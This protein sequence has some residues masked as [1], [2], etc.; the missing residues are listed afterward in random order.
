MRSVSTPLQVTS[1]N[2]PSVTLAAQVVRSHAI[3]AKLGGYTNY[4]LFLDIAQA[5]YKVIRQQAF[6]CSFADEDVLVFLK[7]MGVEDMCLEDVAAVL[8][9]GSTLTNSQCDPFLHSQVAEVHR[10]TW[11]VLNQDPSATL[12]H[13]ERG[14]RPGDG[15]ADII[16]SLVFSRWARRFEERLLHEELITPF[17]WNGEAGV[18]SSSGTFTIPNAVVIWADDVVVLGEDSQADRAPMK[19]Q[20]T[21]VVMVEELLRFGLMANFDKGKTEAVITPRGTGS[22]QVKRLI[23]NTMKSSLP[24]DTAMPGNPKLRLVHKYKH[25]GG[26]VT[27]GAKMRPEIQHRVAQA[28]QQFKTYRAKVYANP[29]ID[30]P[31]RMTVLTATALTTLHY[32]AGIWSSLTQ[33]EQQMWHTA[34]MKLYRGTLLKLFTHKQILHMTDDQVLIHTQQYRPS[35]TLRLLRLRWY[36]GAIRRDCE[37]LWAVLAMEGQ[38]LGLVLEDL[39]WTYSQLKGFTVLPDPEEDIHAW[40][41]L[42]A[43]RPGK[44]AGLLKRAAT[45]DWLQW[46]MRAKVVDYHRRALDLLQE[47]GAPVPQATLEYKDAAHHCF[48][49]IQDFPTYRAWAVHSFKKHGRINKWR[50]LQRGATCMACAR[51]FP[52]EARLTRHL[53][54]VQTCARTVASLELWVPKQPYFGSSKV[55]QSEEQLPMDV[56]EDTDAQQLPPEQGI[57][58]TAEMH[59]FL[60]QALQ[61]D[62]AS[63]PHTTEMLQVLQEHAV[64]HSE[65]LEVEALV[66]RQH[67]ECQD[68]IATTFN[69][70]ATRSR[71]DGMV[72]SRPL[73]LNEC[74]EGLSEVQH[75]TPSIPLRMP[76][77]Y[78]YILHLYAGVRREGDFH[79]YMEQCRPPDGYSFFVASVDLVLDSELGDLTSRPAQSY[80]IQMAARGGVYA[81]LGGPPCESWSVARFR[82]YMTGSGPRPVRSGESLMEEIWGLKTLRL[83][84]IRQ[85]DVANQLLLFMMLLLVV[86]WLVGGIALLEH[87]ELPQPKNDRQPPSI[88]LTPIFKFIGSLKGVHCLHI[89]QGYWGAKSPKP[90]ALMIIAR[91]VCTQFLYDA[92]DSTRTRTTLPQALPMGRVQNGQGYAT[93]ELKRYPPALC[94]G[95]CAICYRLLPYIDHVPAKD[96][97]YHEVFQRFATAYHAS[98]EDIDGADYVF[99]PQKHRMNDMNK[100]GASNP[101]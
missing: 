20:H 42:M 21:C 8:E 73:S 82:Y 55:R 72:T 44:W 71:P 5:F 19:L 94:A 18:L 33:Y 77:R 35:V 64:C 34:H 49:C 48:I 87:P 7:R 40:H 11:F 51:T 43:T 53:R 89:H 57:P 52:A 56:W 83:R 23:F 41:T 30:I 14:T 50:R 47:A 9:G 45:H 63:G 28:Q 12:V 90:T 65:I 99:R 68:A 88:W 60:Q 81:I 16:W 13:T 61:Q 85:V 92:I 80:W 54:S 69:E 66:N 37:Q 10:S 15:F 26:W 6:E 31:T 25:L 46:N 67:P 39:R 91:G 4:S 86:Q 17:T 3:A 97:D 93:A 95:L 38:W 62:W 27:Y 98:T 70:L 75:F 24:L 1:H 32:N 74:L 59:A 100:L 29:N 79:S 58:M 36:G 96:D 101:T 2:S 78:R 84:D 76:T 22:Q